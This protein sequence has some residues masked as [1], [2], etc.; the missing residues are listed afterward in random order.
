MLTCLCAH[1]VETVYVY[2]NENGYV[3]NCS[4]KRV[5]VKVHIPQ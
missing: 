4:H 2:E 5:S 1:V 3:S